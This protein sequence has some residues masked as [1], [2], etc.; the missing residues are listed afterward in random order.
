ME[1]SQYANREIDAK[2]SNLLEHMK[3]FET[4]TAD[5]LERILEQTTRTNGRVTKLERWQSYTLGFCAAISL[6]LIPVII[7]LIE[8]RI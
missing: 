6:L 8:Q 7:F 1:P 3:G 2:F 5:S 4:D